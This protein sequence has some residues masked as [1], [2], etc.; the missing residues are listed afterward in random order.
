LRQ[1]IEANVPLVFVGESEAV[2]TH[3]GVLNTQMDEIVVEALPTHIPSEIEVDLSQLQAI[4]DQITVA[5]LPTT[6]DYTIMD[7]PE[8]IVVSAIEHVEQ[9]LEPETVSE[10]P[11]ITEGAGD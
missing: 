11:E 10:A 6:A 2:K 7:D 8:K 5:Q 3:N 4:G 9:S 1:K